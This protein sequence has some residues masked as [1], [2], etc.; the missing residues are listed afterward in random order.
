[1]PTPPAESKLSLR[2]RQILEL[3]RQGKSNN[4]IAFDLGIGVGTVKQHVVALFRKLKVTNRAMAVSRSTENSGFTPGTPHIDSDEVILERRPCV[5]LSLIFQEPHPSS[6]RLLHSIMAAFAQETGDILLSRREKGC[7]LVLGID[8]V[9]ESDPV[10]A[11][12]KAGEV[13]QSLEDQGHGSKGLKGAIAAGL[14]VASMFRRGGWSGEAIAGSAIVLARRRAEEAER[15][16]LLLDPSFI[17]VLRLCDIH[18]HD[19]RL[20]NNHPVPCSLDHPQFIAWSTRHNET[21]F[22]GRRED[23]SALTDLSAP[24]DSSQA[25]ITFL[26]GEPGI[27]KSRVCDHLFLM[28]REENK[29]TQLFRCLPFE[30]SVTFWDVGASVACDIQAVMGRVVEGG[31]NQI[32]FLDNIHWMN[33]KVKIALMD[34]WATT[35]KNILIFERAGMIPKNNPGLKLCP[36]GEMDT[37]LLA[38]EMMDP[39]LGSPSHLKQ[40]A[41]TIA[42]MAGGNPFFAVEAARCR[43][44]VTNLITSGEKNKPFLPLQIIMR[45]MAHLDALLPDRRLL[46]VAA[47][48]AGGIDPENL[49]FAMG[50]DKMAVQSSIDHALECGVLQ[51]T[52]NDRVHFAHPMVQ[53]VIHFVGIDK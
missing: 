42:A 7:D 6:L 30:G 50:E 53:N 25:G 47:S 48:C 36:M 26:Y 11:L 18:L 28:L 45:V 17:E 10:R 8:Q 24:H 23:I 2:Q 13:A 49:A 9:R 29:K 31:Q 33:E 34:H 35:G 51:Y 43:T 46:R 16:T 38:F 14:A 40:A 22:I 20:H 5:V 1:M 21:P 3:I 12:Q 4:E 19:H 27:G 15:G 37:R 39:A 41:R 32:I 44:M 52:E